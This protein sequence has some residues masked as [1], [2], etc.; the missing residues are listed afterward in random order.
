MEPAV[1][2]T[3]VEV[4][5][6][7]AFPHQREEVSYDSQAAGGGEQTSRDT[8]VAALTRDLDGPHRAQALEGLCDMLV[9][10][11]RRAFCCPSATKRFVILRSVRHKGRCRTAK[12]LV[13]VARSFEVI[14]IFRTAVLL[15]YEV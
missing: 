9:H 8:L 13:F 10:G 7:L 15:L 12:R 3:A 14:Q 11:E 4:V 5:R 1:E 6:M 2:R